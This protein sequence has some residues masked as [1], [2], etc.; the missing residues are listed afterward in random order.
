M[1]SVVNEFAND[2]V[3]LFSDI[4]YLIA[5]TLSSTSTESVPATSLNL[6]EGDAMLLSFIHDVSD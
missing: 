3:R 6:N 1:P 5:K 2:T 4:Q